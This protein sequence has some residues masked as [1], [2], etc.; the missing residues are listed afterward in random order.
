M[1]INRYNEEDAPNMYFKAIK[2]G[3]NYIILYMRNP[4]TISSIKQHSSD[5]C[6]PPKR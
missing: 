5:T 4:N 1:T 3:R 6:G 2:D